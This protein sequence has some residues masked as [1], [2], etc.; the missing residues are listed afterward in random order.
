MILYQN[1]SFEGHYRKGTVIIS[2]PLVES[3]CSQRKESRR[4]SFCRTW[5]LMTT[6]RE[7]YASHCLANTLHGFPEE[8]HEWLI[9]SSPVAIMF[10]NGINIE[11]HFLTR[12]VLVHATLVHT[13]YQGVVMS[14]C[15]VLTEF[16]SP[17]SVSTLENKRGRFPK[18]LYIFVC[19]LAKL[20]QKMTS[21]W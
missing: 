19:R 11:L 7:V 10:S 14:L 21:F 9:T 6:L 12:F 16:V 18:N 5:R 2:L 20:I 13:I 17:H 4:I 3:H 15:T 1:V 8:K